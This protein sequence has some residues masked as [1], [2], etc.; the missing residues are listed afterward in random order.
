[1]LI[2]MDDSNAALELDPFARLDNLVQRARSRATVASGRIPEPMPAHK[3][4]AELD[5]ND[6]KTR[7]SF[8][9]SL[10]GG[11]LQSSDSMHEGLDPERVAALLDLE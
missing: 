7:E 9:N 6:P 8:L 1:M 5:F 10:N 11:S 4:A 3:Q 2:R